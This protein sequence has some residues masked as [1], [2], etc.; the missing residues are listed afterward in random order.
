MNFADQSQAAAGIELSAAEYLELEG[1]SAI[2][3]GN[4]DNFNVAQCAFAW[5]PER[6][7][8]LAEECMREYFD[9]LPQCR[10]PS[11]RLRRFATAMGLHMFARLAA[12][13]EWQFVGRN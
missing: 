13:V 2:A 5:G 6:W 1:I 7:G 9:G 4:G 10:Q 12:Q 11:D 8:T 3:I